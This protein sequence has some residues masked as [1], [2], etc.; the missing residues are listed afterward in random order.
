MNMSIHARLRRRPSSRP[1]ITNHIRARG[2][3]VS[4]QESSSDS[5]GFELVSDEFQASSAS[6]SS[7][8]TSLCCK[9]Q[10]K[11]RETG[12]RQEG[13]KAKRWENTK[14]DD[15]VV[16]MTAEKG[17]VK[18]DIPIQMTGKSMPWASLP[19]QILFSIFDFASRPLIT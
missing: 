17:D 10:K 4:Y 15:R 13:K 11:R 14:K 2:K 5:D 9:S 7:Y 12:Q 6:S 16:A 19:Y 8:A 1:P 3:R 18:S